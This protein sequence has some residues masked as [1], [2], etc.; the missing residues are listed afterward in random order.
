[1]PP[2]ELELLEEELEWPPEDEDEDEDDEVAPELELLELLEELL[3]LLE[4]L[5]E[6]LELLP[7]EL[8]ELLLEDP[9]HP[10]RAA[11]SSS[12]PRSAPLPRGVRPRVRLLTVSRLTKIDMA[13][14]PGCPYFWSGR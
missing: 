2:E 12:V 10:A 4:L 9:P 3:E 7:E 11:A 8:P 6:P 14:A 1:V 13:R 5:E